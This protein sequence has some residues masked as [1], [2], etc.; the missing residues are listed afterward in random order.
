MKK[1]TSD[2]EEKYKTCGRCA[3]ES[4]PDITGSVCYLCKRNATDNRI[5][6]FEEKK[7][8]KENK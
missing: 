7:E 2:L 3:H 5:D 4:E 6:W 1:K 8:E